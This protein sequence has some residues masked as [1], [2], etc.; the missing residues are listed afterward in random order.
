MS[1]GLR[2]PHRNFAGPGKIGVGQVG[3][4]WTR[5]VQLVLA[6]AH[7]A[8]IAEATLQRPVGRLVSWLVEEAGLPGL[9]NEYAQVVQRLHQLLVPSEPWS[10]PA[11]GSQHDVGEVSIAGIFTKVP[12]H[13][14]L[15]AEEL[16]S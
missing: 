16:T 9:P 14:R 13:L 10:R 4:R 3:M 5:A 11:V 15:V 8:Q 7:G 12:P 1:I 2:G 6:I